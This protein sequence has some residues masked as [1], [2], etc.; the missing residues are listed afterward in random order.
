MDRRRFL[1]ALGTGLA[2]AALPRL[3]LASVPHRQAVIGAAWRGPNPTDP[4]FAGA[5]VA[6][7]EARTLTI[8]YSVPLPTRPHGLLAE[9]EGGLL[10]CGVRPGSWML[11]CDGNGKLM[12]QIDLAAEGSARLGG[13]VVRASAGERFYTTETDM[14]TGRGVIGVRDVR[15]LQKLTQWETHGIDPHQLLLD[16]QG[17]LM[18]ANGGVPRTL[19]DKKY[20]LPRMDSSLVRI[21]STDGKLLRQW[22]LDDPRLSLRHLAWNSSHEGKPLLGIAMQAEHDVAATRATAPI[23]AVLDGDTLSI[24][25]RAGD[26]VGYAGDI[27]AAQGGGFALSSNQV[28]LAQLWQP[29]IPERL[30]PIVRL[31]EAYALTAWPGPPLSGGV[32]VATALGLGRWHPTE[33]PL[34]LPWPQPMALDNHWVLLN[35]VDGRSA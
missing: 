7:W 2:G 32:L 6:D 24:P 3:A 29:A 33:K 19:A 28:G 10:V 11:R 17:H 30:T 14:T 4:Y 9:A 13:H 18:V 34:L 26:G 22:R 31:Q 5:L 23:L 16:A 1:Y 35:E 15:S 20:D 25:T 8:R 27:A 12:Q 21:D